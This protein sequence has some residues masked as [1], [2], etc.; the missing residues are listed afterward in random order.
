MPGDNVAVQAVARQRRFEAGN[1]AMVRPKVVRRNAV[2]ALAACCA[3][4]LQFALATEAAAA[5]AT[6]YVAAGGTNAGNDCTSP[7]APCATISFALTKAVAGDTIDVSGTISDDVTVSLSVTIT[8][9]GAPSGSPAVVEGDGEGSVLAIDAGNVSLDD[10]T[11]RD[12]S[13]GTTDQFGAGIWS[14]A[15]GTTVTGSTI[16][17]NGGPGIE[18]DGPLL[19]LTDST[20]TDNG[21]AGVENGLSE[22]EV[23]DST[24]TD[25]AGAGVAQ[26][27]DG[28]VAVSDSSVSDNVGGLSDGFGSL[29]VTGS[30]VAHNTGFGI[31]SAAVECNPPNFAA[32]CPVDVS[33]T[34]ITDNTGV[35]LA[36]DAGGVSSSTISGNGEGGV[37]AY[38]HPLTVT[39]SVI[40]DNTGPGLTTEDCLNFSGVGPVDLSCPLMVT[41]SR[42][43]SNTQGG[44]VAGSGASVTG[45]TIADNGG[46]GVE[47]GTFN[48]SVSA[49]NVTGN[50][51]VGIEAEQGAAVSGS[52]ISHNGGGG[53]FV[54]GGGGNLE[55]QE[56]GAGAI[57]I[58]GDTIAR[59]SAAN[60][61]GIYLCECSDLPSAINVSDNTVTGN[62]ATDGG[63]IDNASPYVAAIS[64]N[65][66]EGN[67]ATDGG[68]IYNDGLASL[69]ATT[70]SG[71]V[72]TAGA[73]VYNSHPATEAEPRML[74]TAADIFDGTCDN[75]GGWDDAGYNVGSD[76]TCLAGGTDDVDYG[77][78]L[79]AS[80]V[81]GPLAP[82][83]GPTETMLPLR[84]DPA[85]GIVPNGIAV[86]LQGSTVSLCP[87]TDQRGVESSP[88]LACNVGS[89]QY[90]GTLT[91][92]APSATIT[93]GEVMPL[94]TPSYSGF[95]DGY[96]A[97]SLARPAHCTTAATSASRPGTYPVFCAGAAD[98]YYSLTYVSG[99]LRVRLPPFSLVFRGSVTYA[100]SGEIAAGRVAVDPS[101]GAITSVTGTITVPGWPAGTATVRVEIVQFLG[102]Y[103]G[104]ISVSDSSAHL[105][106]VAV[107]LSTGLTR[108]PGGEVTGT[109]VGSHASRPYT[110]QFTV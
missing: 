2:V 35:G 95:V 109:A 41:D 26:S 44:I 4:G 56:Q 58:A 76:G 79:R 11:I 104:T 73:A 86:A 32:G 50:A 99:R 100:K 38:Y 40:S 13:P 94:L 71:N 45:S 22:L 43:A 97:S 24:I 84:G 87:T 83:G 55:V 62:T 60:G 61:G 46:T 25:N 80:V 107:V 29:T 31:S 14:E 9:A 6:L 36:M 15:F 90:V 27:S 33:S 37:V 20:V 110:L 51:R 68:G 70:L 91:I 42:V 34:T 53:L 67:T 78:G 8:G 5:L 59:N 89:V 81:L 85:V 92:S 105:K 72:A 49:S 1:G 3:F 64:D 28:S 74:A 106:T 10:L 19:T 75:L 93:E 39:G 16:S 82:N 88:G 17:G 18:N 77:S 54:N 47:N 108:T 48:L 101:S 69:S 102:R 103:V 52:V 7:S 30:V 12:G 21:G 65:T 63:G 98:P 66:I 23:A 57:D 96:G